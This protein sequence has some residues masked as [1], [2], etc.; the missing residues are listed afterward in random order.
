MVWTDKAGRIQGII[1][2]TH[3]D[4]DTLINESVQSL[5]VDGFVDRF[6][7]IC[8]EVLAGGKPRE[9]TY[10]V[11]FRGN[12]EVRRCRIM[13]ATGGILAINYKIEY[14]C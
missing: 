9:F 8:K 6:Q 14:L 12:L 7:K 3:P 13:K 5:F 10:L 2:S 1:N 4:P 11:N